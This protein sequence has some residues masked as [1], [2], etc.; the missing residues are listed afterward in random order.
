MTTLNFIFYNIGLMVDSR[1]RRF[2][3]LDEDIRKIIFP[4]PARIMR[5]E[6]ADIAYPPDMIAYPVVLRIKVVHFFPCNLFA[7]G[8]G[9]QHR[10]VAMPSPA[11]IVY[12]PRPRLLIKLPEHAH[13]VIAV[14]IVPDLLALV[15]ENG[16]GITRDRAFHQVRKKAMQL[17]PRMV[18]TRQTAA[19]KNAGLHPKIPAIFLYQDIGCHFGGAK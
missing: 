17:R 11:C 6:F 14:D 12:L 19:P 1:S 4:I 13:Q 15:S 16:I 5:L 9:F 3:Y 8:N 18:W 10:T 7:A 2:E